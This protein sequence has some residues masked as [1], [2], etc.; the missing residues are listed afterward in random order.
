MEQEEIKKEEGKEKTKEASLENE[1]TSAEPVESPEGATP[2]QPTEGELLWKE[3]YKFKE[4][5]D[6]IDKRKEEEDKSLTKLKGDIRGLNSQ[7]KKLSSNQIRIIETLGIFVALFTFISVNI[8]IFRNVSDLLSAIL[9]SIILAALTGIIIL[10]VILVIHSY[11]KEDKS[12]WKKFR[13]LIGLFIGLIVLGLIGSLVFKLKL[14][15]D[16]NKENSQINTE[17]QPVNSNP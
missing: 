12:W 6:E 3:L 11:E 13:I 10:T 7:I 2:K 4:W 15:P 9:F 1:E 5:K 16:I 17:I 8:Q 14:N